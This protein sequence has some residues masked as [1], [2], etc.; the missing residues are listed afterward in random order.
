MTFDA[1]TIAE[2]KFEANGDDLRLFT[3]IVNVLLN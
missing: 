3:Q 1:E 2:V